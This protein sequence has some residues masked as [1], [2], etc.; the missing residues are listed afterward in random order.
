[1][2]PEQPEDKAPAQP[3]DKAGAQPADEASTEPT[4]HPTAGARGAAP[5]RPGGLPVLV[6]GK[7]EL[8]STG[9]VRS[10]PAGAP[11]ISSDGRFVAFVSESGDL[12]A[13]DANGAADVF[14]RD[15]ALNRT[16][17][18]SASIYGGSAAGSSLQPS[19]SADG[20][21]VAFTSA[22]PDLVEDDSN[23]S[24]DVFLHDLRTGITQ[25]VSRGSRGE[26]ADNDSYSPSL[27][28]DGRFVA[29][30]SMATNLDPHD[31]NAS[32]DVFMFDRLTGRTTLVS[33]GSDG[34]SGHGPSGQPS[35]SANGR[36]IA[37]TSAA[38]FAA[39]DTNDDMDVYVHDMVTGE[40]ELVSR[41]TDGSAGNG[42]SLE[43]ALSADGD[44]VAFTSVADNLIEGDTNAASDVFV[45]RRS[46]GETDLISA[47]PDGL[48]GDG[49]SRAPGISGD[50]ARVAFLSA[51][52]DLTPGTTRSAGSTG[53]AEPVAVP[54]AAVPDQ[55][56]AYV[57]DLDGAGTALAAGTRRR[58]PGDGESTGVAISSWGR[59]VAFS[60]TSTDLPGA[61][62]DALP[63]E[64]VYVAGLR[65]AHVPAP[66]VIPPDGQ[67]AGSGSDEE[68]QS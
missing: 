30:S 11:A 10:L 26:L 27:S 39:D 23:G 51:A 15:T 40:N 34:Q 43:P 19:I 54:D 58:T 68:P 48:P 45:R 1:M 53:S 61:P 41:A 62:E 56:H 25:L 36:L 16:V 29:Y 32:P 2:T 35:I 13:D 52:G 49:P 33:A 64:H 3:T 4:G 5:R 46:T 20:R 18:V 47:T 59:H 55:D 42:A 57:R 6:V 31:T 63:G 12:V 60:D 44:V 9:G 14:V 8:V 17:L 67:R 50:G 28:A 66:S 37:F 38:R 24:L 65:T 7:P 22:A 21:F